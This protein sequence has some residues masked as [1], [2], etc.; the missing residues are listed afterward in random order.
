MAAD[1]TSQ[2]KSIGAVRQL[3]ELLRFCESQRVDW[4]EV[5]KNRVYSLLQ[6]SVDKFPSA[7]YCHSRDFILLFRQIRSSFMLSEKQSMHRDAERSG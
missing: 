1:A 6:L 4:N 7:L 5:I 3:A 2:I